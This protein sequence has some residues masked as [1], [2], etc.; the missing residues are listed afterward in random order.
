MVADGLEPEP[1]GHN[2]LH[3]DSALAEAV[4][5]AAEEL[6]FLSVEEEEVEGARWVEGGHGSI[7]Q[8]AETD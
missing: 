2:P 5:E 6:A 1:E 4:D 7:D 3:G 8:M